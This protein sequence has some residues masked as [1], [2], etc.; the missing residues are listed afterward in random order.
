MG[1]I[2]QEGKIYF[3]YCRI[4]KEWEYD[5]SLLYQ[6]ELLRKKFWELSEREDGIRYELVSEKDSGNKWKRPE[7]NKMISKLEVDS[8]LPF[9]EQKYWWILIF[10]IDRLARNSKD[11][12]RIE[13]LLD[14]WYKII[15]YTETIENTPTG[16]L[17]F[18]MLC[19]FAIFESE[20][21]SSRMSLTQISNIL[22]WDYAKLGWDLWFGYKYIK[23]DKWKSIKIVINESEAKVIRLIYDLK[24]TTTLTYWEIA[25]KVNSIYKTNYN[26]DFIESIIYNSNL[27]WWATDDGSIKYN[28][29]FV[30]RLSINDEIVKE[31]IDK[32][33]ME[34]IWN[35]IQIKWKN[36]I[37]SDIHI[38]VSSPDLAIVSEKIYLA[39]RALKRD[40]NKS[41]EKKNYLFDGLMYYISNK[42]I[43]KQLKNKPTKGFQYYWV[44]DDDFTEWFLVKQVSEKKIEEI[45]FRSKDIKKI[46]SLINWTVYIGQWNNEVD[47]LNMMITN[48]TSQCKLEI[49]HYKGIISYYKSKVLKS[50][51]EIL[52]WSNEATNEDILH[53]EN[54]ITD[55]KL[56][57]YA[58]EQRLE[59]IKSVYDSIWKFSKKETYDIIPYIHKEIL[60]KTIILEKVVLDFR[61]RQWKLYFKELW[62]SVLGSKY[63]TFRF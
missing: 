60:Y 50:K 57:I 4:S 55:A 7:F 48:Y 28:G 36:A 45:I 15:S 63:D 33:I 49:A 22:K 40:Y 51:E 39:V 25:Q 58:H 38:V 47:I 46:I 31:Y 53:M 43:E 59:K 3:L 10:K 2:K 11:F 34:W 56:Y 30:R 20:K 13:E 35:E 52:L 23:D 18:R 16:R 19:S 32:K 12:I 8:T 54:L 62:S 1:E 6:E 24:S 27:I 5:D 61:V 29:Y 42:E 26:K 17:L 37:D 41:G 9:D 44:K 14:K 21:L